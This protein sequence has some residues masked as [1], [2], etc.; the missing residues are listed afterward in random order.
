M[1]NPGSSAD[2]FY[3][4]GTFTV[5]PAGL[6]TE[7]KQDTQIAQGAKLASETVTRVSSSATVVTLKASN[8]SRRS[9]KIVNESTSGLYVKFGATAT[10][11]DYTVYLPPG[12]LAA[13]YAY[14]EAPLPIYTGIVTGIWSSANGAAQVTE[15]A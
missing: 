8:G 12:T 7:A 10:A 9:L 3:V 2:P 4:A 6:A 11:T 5:D 13:G 1:A 14:Y 15:G